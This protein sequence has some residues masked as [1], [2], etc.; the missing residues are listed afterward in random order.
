MLNAQQLVVSRKKKD[1]NGYEYAL[2]FVLSDNN[3]LH[4]VKRILKSNNTSTKLSPKKQNFILKT[5]F[6]NQNIQQSPPINIKKKY[7]T[8]DNCNKNDIGSQKSKK[9]QKSNSSLSIYDKNN[10]S[11]YSQNYLIRSNNSN[12]GV[13]KERQYYKYTNN[14]INKMNILST[15]YK[16]CCTKINNMKKHKQ[17]IEEIK[18]ENEEL[19][20]R[21]QKMRQ[22]KINQIEKKK[23]IF[24]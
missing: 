17:K 16:D 23:K 19:K 15:K 18:K 2:Y 22:D 12:M 21:I 3:K 13:E 14:L 5:F 6:H 20:K 8:L 7:S 24:K 10:N 9:L 1:R 4:P 11:I